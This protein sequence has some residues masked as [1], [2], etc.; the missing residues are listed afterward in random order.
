VELSG[1]DGG[2]VHV[3][4]DTRPSL[5]IFFEERRL[6]TRLDTGDRSGE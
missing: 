5:E 1:L 3:A 6:Q 2:S 4:E